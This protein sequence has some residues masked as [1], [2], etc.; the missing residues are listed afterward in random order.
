MYHSTYT[1]YSRGVSVLVHRTVY[2]QL[3]DKLI[4]VEGRYVILLC[5]IYQL[6]SIIAAVY[7]PPPFSLEVLRILL[8]HQLGSPDPPFIVLGDL[9]CYM[10]PGLDKHPSPVNGRKMAR[11]ALRKFTEE[12]GWIDPWRDRNPQLKTIL[13]VLKHTSPC[14]G[15][16]FAYAPLRQHTSCT[17]F[18]IW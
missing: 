15:L 10:D 14:L 16:T 8:T 17:T 13:I 5:R 7:V 3:I 1:S 9:N 12:V 18:N 2:F 4:D 6:K 11:M